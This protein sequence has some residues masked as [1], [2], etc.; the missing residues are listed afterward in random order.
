MNNMKDIVGY[1]GLYKIDTNGDI[2]SYDKIVKFYG[3]RNALRKGKKLKTRFDRYGYKRIQLRKDGISR[4]HS[5][6]RLIAETYLKNI[7]NKPQINHINGI[8]DD[9][10]LENLEWCTNQENIIHAVEHGLIIPPKNKKIKEKIYNGKN[11]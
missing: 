4:T 10:R 6:H 3:G 11:L 9:N 7:E 1:E 8:K 2:Y 5:I